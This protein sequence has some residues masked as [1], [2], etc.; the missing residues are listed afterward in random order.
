[1]SER[2][3][4][5]PVVLA[6]WRSSKPRII[7][8]LLLTTVP[9]LVIAS[10][11]IPPLLPVVG[12]VVG[13]SLATAGCHL[14]NAV[15]E[16]PRDALMHRTRQRPIASGQLSGAVAGVTAVLACVCGIAVTSVLSGPVA[17]ALTAAAVGVYVLVYTVWLKPRTPQNIVWGGAAGAFPPLIAW[18]AVG[19]LASPLP[20]LLFA[21]VFCWTPAHYWPLA[22][23]HRGD[24]VRAGVPM[25]PVVAPLGVVVGAVR[26]YLVATAALGCAAVALVAADRAV[27]STA[28]GTVLG[29]G[30]VVTVAAGGGWWWRGTAGL[31]LLDASQRAGGVSD[32]GAVRAAAMRAFHRAN[33]WLGGWVL[34]AVAAAA[35]P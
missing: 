23:A 24:Y 30:L 19:D 32:P 28:A 1:M 26:R 31:A 17:G 33:A 34:L 21:I 13:G 20:W 18:S 11:G 29:A 9:A 22:V 16:R 7:V 12:V 25:L 3:T 2:A 14:A 4:A 8:L 35:L 27:T 5:A 10:G 6:L 15:I